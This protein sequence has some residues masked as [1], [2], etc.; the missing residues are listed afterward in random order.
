MSS[1]ARQLS[2]GTRP[3]PSW[4]LRPLSSD[5]LRNE[6]NLY[7]SDNSCETAKELSME[8]RHTLMGK[9]AD[10]SW[11]RGMSSFSYQGRLYLP[12]TSYSSSGVGG[13]AKPSLVTCCP[14]RR[15][16]RGPGTFIVM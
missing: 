15:S 2:L 10:G 8:T 13:S 5:I 12:E 14:H 7:M 6:R 1:S 11:K 16:V 4:G 3:S 9:G